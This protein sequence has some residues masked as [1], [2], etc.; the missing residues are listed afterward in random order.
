MCIRYE[1]NNKTTTFG[2]GYH[3][4][5][6]HSKSDDRTQGADARTEREDESVSVRVRENRERHA[7]VCVMQ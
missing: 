5:L 6:Q 4:V 7:W 3:A 2:R 1:N